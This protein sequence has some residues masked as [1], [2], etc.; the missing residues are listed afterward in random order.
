MKKN[1]LTKTLILALGLTFMGGFSAKAATYTV[2]SGD[3]LFKIGQVFNT[4]SNALI[5]RNNL[6]SS[7]IYP[8]QAIDVPAN[9]Y[10]VKSGDS[11][12]LI[13]RNSGIALDTLRSANN[14]W[15]NII[16]PGQ[17]FLIPVKSNSTTTNNGLTLSKAG[18]Y[19]SQSDVDLMA[20]LVTS[21]AENQPYNAKVAVAAVVLNRVKSNLYPN[22]IRDVIYEVS[23]GYYQFTPVLNGM[24]NKPASE[25]S[26]AA[27][28]D[29][30]NG[31][32][33][34]KGALYYFD[35]S[36]TNQ[37]LWSKPI[38]IRIDRMV[39]TYR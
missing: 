39:F 32:D 26:K 35:D 21:E 29:A 7:V 5:S 16:Y 28:L 15:D 3:S 10:T 17:K 8:G 18:V 37:W 27:V 36:T 33:P 9:V 6:A 20:R 38:A 24:I 12:F 19:Y 2:K 4:N 14:K 30:L 11:L 34:T 31:I 22:T 13:A 25:S 1:N 23:G